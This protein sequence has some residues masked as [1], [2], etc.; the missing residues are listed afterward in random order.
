M[1]TGW[2]A[3][4]ARL[5]G[6]C[7]NLL[8][9]SQKPAEIGPCCDEPHKTGLPTE[10]CATIWPG[11]WRRTKD[12]PMSSWQARVLNML[13]R[14]QVRRR[15]K[16]NPSPARARAILGRHSL[17][18]PAGANYRASTLGGI[19]GEWVTR[20]RSAGSAPV[21]LYLHGGGYFACSP[22][23]HRPITASFA[24]AGF[25][26]FVPD[27]RLAP[28]HPY[29]A[30]VDDAETVWNAL[31]AAGHDAGTLTVAGDSAGG[32]LALA[33]MIR[34]RGEGIALPAAAVLFSPW[35]DLA[36][37]GN[38]LRT[39]AQRDPMFRPQGV[40]D[41][42]AWYLN[43]ADPRTP[44]AS[45]LYATLTGLPPLYI[46][47]GEREVLRDDSSRLAARA[48]AE[49]VSVTLTIWPVVPHVWQLACAFVPE[50]RESLRRAAAFLHQHSRA[51]EPAHAVTA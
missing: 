45:P 50:G 18:A 30:A 34:L 15:L 1:R 6:G 4:R 51:S 2:R 8:D 25:D 9:S 13:I 43:G 48:E 20:T 44:E 10:K 5:P 39:N 41:V 3:A 24:K 22:R 40:P 42:A 31:L 38:S 47:V 26:V 11:A 33:L 36:A 17:P 46:E 29:P 19:P 16:G 28:E 7:R 49:G 21:L 12:S 23:T 14:V 35:T 27:Y 32:G 37:T